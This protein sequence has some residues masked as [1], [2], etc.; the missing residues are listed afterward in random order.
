MTQPS[1]ISKSAMLARLALAAE[2]PPRSCRPAVGELD[3]RD[4]RVEQAGVVAAPVER[5]EALEELVRVAAAQVVG[6]RDVEALKLA[7][8]G[9]ADVRD[10]GE[11]ARHARI[12]AAWR[13]TVL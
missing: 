3:G 5:A 12:I 8:D 9:R 1:V 10:G 4:E 7:R 13:A 6:A 2:L 11:L